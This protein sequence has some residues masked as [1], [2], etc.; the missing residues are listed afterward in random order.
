MHSVNGEAVL[1][2]VEGREEGQALDVVPV[3]VPDEYVGV[4]GLAF[5]LIEQGVAEPPQAG[6][7]VDDD[8]A[9]AD[10][11]FGA[12]GVSPVARGQGP[13]GGNRTARSPEAQLQSDLAAREQL[14][15]AAQELGDL[16]GLDDEQVRPRRGRGPDVVLVRLGRADEDL[17]PLEAFVGAHPLADLEAVHARHVEVEHDEVG[18]LAQDQG[19]PLRA[20]HGGVDFVLAPEQP[21]HQIAEVRVVVH[22]H[23]FFHTL[24]RHPVY[25]TCFA[26][27]VNAFSVTAAHRLPGEDADLI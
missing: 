14:L 3:G 25:V 23:D 21:R 22:D 27:F 12:G 15:D 20:V 11:Q 4:D 17:D 5:T 7:R 18:G 13:G 9:V 26:L 16:E 10:A 6:A 8:E 2:H 24:G 1:R 19:K